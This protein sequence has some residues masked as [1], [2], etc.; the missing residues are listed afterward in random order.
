MS[1]ARKYLS[2][3]RHFGLTRNIVFYSLAGGA[4]ILAGIVTSVPT[5]AQQTYPTVLDMH[6]KVSRFALQL[7]NLL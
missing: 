1:Y 7:V 3:N 4:A 5:F 2:R 6:K